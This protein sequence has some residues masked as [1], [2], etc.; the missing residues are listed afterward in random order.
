M[1]LIVP[2]KIVIFVCSLFSLPIVIIALMIGEK[3]NPDKITEMTIVVI[4]LLFFQVL[5]VFD[6]MKHRH[7][8]LGF[9]TEK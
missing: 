2:D 9:D 7:E 8:Y 6:Y 3:A 5:I 4:L 1:K